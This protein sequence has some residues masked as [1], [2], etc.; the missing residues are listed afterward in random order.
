MN[1]LPK[2]QRDPVNLAYGA[3]IGATV[4]V[5]FLTVLVIWA[6][7]QPSVKDWL[8]ATFTHHWIGKGLLATV[9]FFVSGAFVAGGRPRDDAAHAQAGRVLYVVTVASGLVLTAFY[10]YEALIKG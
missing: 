6:E 9:V 2:T 8:K 5:V 4:T 1:H 10:F 7:L 3:L